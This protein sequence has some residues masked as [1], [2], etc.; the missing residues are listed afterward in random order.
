MV[1]FGRRTEV[2]LTKKGPREDI[3]EFAFNRLTQLPS[4]AFLWPK[5]KG[6]LRAWRALLIEFIH[7]SL[8]GSIIC[9]GCDA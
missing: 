2:G 7:I 8:L 1:T 5:V 3:L 9:L 4:R 6:S